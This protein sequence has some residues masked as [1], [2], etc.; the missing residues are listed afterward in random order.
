MSRGDILH[1][2]V[3][4]C[5]NQLSSTFWQQLIDEHNIDK[6]GF[7]SNVEDS[8][9]LNVHFNYSVNDQKYTPRA[10]L[11][12]LETSALDAIKQGSLRKLFGA[13]KSFI[14]GR[15]ATGNCFAN[16]HYTDGAE[17]VDTVMD[18]LRKEAEASD[19]LL[20]FQMTHSISGGTGSGLGTLLLTRIQESYPN[21]LVNTFTVFPSENACANNLETFNSVLSMNLLTHATSGCFM[22]D[23]QA[24]MNTCLNIQKLPFVK[25]DNTNSLIGRSLLGITSCERFSTQIDASL[26]KLICNLVPFPRLHFFLPNISFNNKELETVA[27]DLFHFGENHNSLSSVSLSNGQTMAFASLFRGADLSME[28]IDKK[29]SEFQSKYADRFV[30]WSTNSNLTGVC[31]IAEK[32]VKVSATIVNNSS[33]VNS[34]FQRLIDNFDAMLK[35]KLFLHWYTG[36]GMDELEFNEAVTNLKD[37]VSEF[38]QT[39]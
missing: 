28:I 11:V 18:V 14:S 24:L 22:Y 7:C 29:V 13:T 3:G 21:R 36:E 4:Q 32:N 15:G 10:I 1:L 26:Y 20:A 9:K 6:N 34:I 16:G 17:L 12:D 25:L 33:A 39:V 2:Q 30:E 8:G 5:G 38:N 31:N 19:T 35:S 27:Q 37:F 23:N